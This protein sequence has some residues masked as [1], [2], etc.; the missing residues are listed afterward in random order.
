MSIKFNHKPLRIEDFQ[1]ELVATGQRAVSLFPVMDE[2]ADKV[3]ERERRLFESRGATGGRYW[4]PLRSS[5]VRI[6]TKLGVPDPFA[7]LRR[8]D[9]LMKSLSV[10]GAEFQI[11]EVNDDSFHLATEHEAAEYHAEG[12]AH[13]PARPPLVIPKAQA[14][15]YVKMIKD[16][17]FGIEDA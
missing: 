17:V 15:E 5:T 6:K 13:M 8:T 16:Y 4:S 9:S 2:I 11:L 1:Y 14:Q 12:T 3:L 10:R 7:P